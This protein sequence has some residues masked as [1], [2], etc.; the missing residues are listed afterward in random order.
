MRSITSPKKVDPAKLSRRQGSQLSALICM[1]V[2]LVA[3]AIGAGAVALGHFTEIPWLPIPILLLFDL[4][5]FALY[6][7]GLDRIDAMVLNNRDSLLEELTK[8]SA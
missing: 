1:G 2:V 3:G 5:A 8:V 6:R 4:G 7:A